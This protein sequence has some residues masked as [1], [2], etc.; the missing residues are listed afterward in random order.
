MED[1]SLRIL[2]GIVLEKEPFAKVTYPSAKFY[3]SIQ[4][5]K[6][7]QC[8]DDVE[9]DDGD[10]TT[11][12][13]CA[14]D[15]NSVGSCRN[16]VIMNVCG[17]RVCETSNGETWLNCDADCV[18]PDNGENG[19]VGLIYDEERQNFSSYS[20]RDGMMF[21]VKTKSK[22][23]TVYGID[24]P[25]SSN[26]DLTY[27]TFV[28]VTRIN[29][30]SRVGVENDPDKWILVAHQNVTLSK[31]GRNIVLDYPFTMEAFE[32]RGVYITFEESG[33][34]IAPTNSLPVGEVV[35]ETDELQLLAGSFNKFSF[36]QFSEPWSFYGRM[37]YFIEGLPCKNDL[38]CNDNNIGT[39]DKCIN[40]KCINNIISG[41][42]GNGVC[43]ERES[44]QSCP[45]DCA[46]PNN[47]D[48][49]DTNLSV[50][51][52]SSAVYGIIFEVEA[53]RDITFYELSASIMRSSTN[54]T[55]YSRSGSWSHVSTLDGFTKYYDGS[56]TASGSYFQRTYTVEL[57]ASSIT[58]L[59]T[60]MGTRRTFYITYSSS[61]TQ[62]LSGDVQKGDIQKEN[63]DMV[64]YV[65]GGRGNSISTSKADV[66]F[67][68][69]LSY[70]F[71]LNQNYCDVASDCDD[72]NEATLDTCSEK[73]IC[74]HS[75]KLDVCGKLQIICGYC[76]STQ[77]IFQLIF[78]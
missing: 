75:V 69:S 77:L 44:C 51:S 15:I 35:S 63:D 4:Y 5:S 47:C 56:V 8:Y 29:G 18:F 49:L 26:S 71:G 42:C 41:V 60:P 32:T 62:P 12:D 36:G 28:Y 66:L 54:V 58:L 76:S 24:I 22:S 27:E 73:G 50:S 25:R 48:E 55:I 3:G 74:K 67:A 23:V 68:G 52:A 40:S 61:L 43:E 72:D 10:P 46:A 16:Q 64:L 34:F 21:D 19:V 7:H 17:N 45:Q 13:E 53:K 20:S 70:D 78:S 33:F 11:S 57:A 37:R 38:E 14:F 59:T 6:G 30:L 39:E 1:K 65:G 31:S 9:C 2:E